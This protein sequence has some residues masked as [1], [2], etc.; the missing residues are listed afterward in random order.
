MFTHQM[1]AQLITVCEPTLEQYLLRATKDRHDTL[2]IYDL[3]WKYYEHNKNHPAAAEVL[4]ALATEP[5]E[6]VDLQQRIE[7]LAHSVMCMRS[8]KV[9]YAAPLGVFLR[10]LED[11]IQIAR[12]QQKILDAIKNTASMHPGADEAI[13]QLN[14]K[15]LDITDVSFKFPNRNHHLQTARG[16]PWPP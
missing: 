4:N 6:T 12:V 9:G 16:G 8:D 3:L 7:Y 11:R 2:Y 15:L 13:K 10:E 5:S 1:Y 14:F